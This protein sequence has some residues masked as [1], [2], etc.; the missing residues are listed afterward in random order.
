M[1]ERYYYC[2]THRQVE[3]EEEACA[4]RNRMGPYTTR[5][6]ASRALETAAARNEEWEH[7]PRWNDD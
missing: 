7:D 4:S 3:S 6:E 2:L 5:E 1:S